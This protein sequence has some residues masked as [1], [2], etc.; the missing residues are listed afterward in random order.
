[1]KTKIIYKNNVF[2]LYEKL[3]FFYCIM[4]FFMYPFDKESYGWYLRSTYKNLPDALER[5]NSIHNNY[6]YQKSFK[7]IYRKSL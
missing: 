5:Q 7:P 2:C 4:D 1:M 3:P 6:E